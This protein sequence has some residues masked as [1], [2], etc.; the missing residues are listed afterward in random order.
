MVNLTPG[1]SS[2]PYR[3]TTNDWRDAVKIGRQTE[4][5]PHRSPSQEG[6]T[7][8]RRPH[9]AAKPRP[10]ECAMQDQIGAQGQDAIRWRRGSADNRGAWV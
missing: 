3:R 5:S 9:A 2:E 4:P 1:Q 8:N 10:G 6:W 7:N